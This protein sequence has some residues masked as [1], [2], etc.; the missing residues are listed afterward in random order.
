MD[1]LTSKRKGLG[2]KS[3]D[4]ATETHVPLYPSSSVTDRITYF[5]VLTDCD[6]TYLRSS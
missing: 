5:T 4:I 3:A 6:C 2:K 1:D